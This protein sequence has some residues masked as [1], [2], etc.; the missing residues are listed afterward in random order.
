[1]DELSTKTLT[2]LQDVNAASAFEMISHRSLIR[3]PESNL[4]TE[5]KEINTERKEINT[6]RRMERPQTLVE[7]VY[8]NGDSLQRQL[9]ERSKFKKQNRLFSSRNL[10]LLDL[11]QQHKQMLTRAKTVQDLPVAK[12][13][14]ED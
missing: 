8:A 6:E 1:M 4:N 2:N 5:R 7:D 3:N 11:L 14:Q 12:Q 13:K 10:N 9:T